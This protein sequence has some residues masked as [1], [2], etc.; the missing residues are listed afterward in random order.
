VVVFAAVVPT[1]PSLRRTA[2]S[3]ERSRPPL[4]AAQ[5]AAS[6]VGDAVGDADGGIGAAAVKRVRRWIAKPSAGALRFR[7]A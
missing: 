1:R 3:A 2:R 7:A 4:R 6:A 5:S